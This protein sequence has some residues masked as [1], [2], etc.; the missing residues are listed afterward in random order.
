MDAYDYVDTAENFL[1]QEAE[2]EANSTPVYL[3]LK[4]NDRRWLLFADFK[5]IGIYICGR[6]GW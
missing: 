4:K 2:L 3:K 6:D 1:E 5:W